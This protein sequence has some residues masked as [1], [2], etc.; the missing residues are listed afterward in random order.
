MYRVISA[1]ATVG[2]ILLVHIYMRE[3][4]LHAEVQRL[5]LAAAGALWGGMA[6]LTAITQG[7]SDAFIYFQF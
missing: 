3:R 7:G 2:G 5:P 1:L 6:F 4:K